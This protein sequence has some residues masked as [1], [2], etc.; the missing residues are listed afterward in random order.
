MS[1]HVGLRWAI[2]NGRGEEAA[3]QLDQ[4]ELGSDPNKNGKRPPTKNGIFEHSSE[5]GRF[6]YHSRRGKSKT[7]KIEGGVVNVGTCWEP[8]GTNGSQHRSLGASPLMPNGLN[9]QKTSTL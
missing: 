4:M 7:K 8:S 2:S 3:V 5:N 9:S 6:F 1:L